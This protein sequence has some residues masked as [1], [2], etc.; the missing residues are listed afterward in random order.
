MHSF[1]TAPRYDNLQGPVPSSNNP[2]PHPCWPW[3]V[4]SP[5][6]RWLQFGNVHEP[7]SCILD[8]HAAP[9]MDEDPLVDDDEVRCS[10]L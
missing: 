3:R 1:E 9:I 6:H 8:C 2:R 10:L 4:V 5:L 7:N